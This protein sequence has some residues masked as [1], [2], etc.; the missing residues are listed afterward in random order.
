MVSVEVRTQG[1]KRLSAKFKRISVNVNNKLAPEVVKEGFQFI[2]KIMPR[3]RGA[4]KRALKFITR[5]RSGQ[6]VQMQ[7]VQ[8]RRN[9][10][11]YHLWLNGINSPYLKS[12][13][14]RGNISVSAF[15]ARIISGKI[16]YMRAGSDY[17][18][19]MIVQKTKEKLK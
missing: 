7:P 4:A 19:K 1:T 9:P 17:M 12:D 10:R 14:T 13:G 5:K 18:R 6:I 16:N 15:Q 11:P 3:D 8:G 2:Q